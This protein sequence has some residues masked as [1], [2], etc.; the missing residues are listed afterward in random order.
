MQ[1]IPWLQM[2]LI[3]VLLAV[4]L[5]VIA[6]EPSYLYLYVVYK[7]DVIDDILL[8]HSHVKF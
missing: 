1:I 4:V 3:Y 7:R 8:S 5:D 6:P 2:W